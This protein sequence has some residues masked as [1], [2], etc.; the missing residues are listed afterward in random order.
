MT[1]HAA[2]MFCWTQL[3][4]PHTDA[5]KKFYS[6][7]FGWTTEDTTISG[8]VFTLLKKRDKDIGGLY[9]LQPQERSQ[10]TGPN[11]SSFIAC[12]NTDRTVA[13]IKQNGGTVLMEPFDVLDHGRSAV[14]EDPTRAAFGL[15][16]AKK[17]IGAGVV[18]EVGSMCW[19]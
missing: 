18:N 12:E 1:Q 16:Q 17:Q 13:Q 8:Q 19:N 11:W 14:C 4:T 5:A 10:N 7:L 15:W 6:G 9:A 2:G 3:G